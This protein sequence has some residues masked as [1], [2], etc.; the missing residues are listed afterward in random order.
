MSSTTPQ[1]YVIWKC[2]SFTSDHFHILIDPTCKRTR[3]SHEELP[4]ENDLVVAS[5]LH[6]LVLD[7]KSSHYMQKKYSA[8]GREVQVTKCLLMSSMKRENTLPKTGLVFISFLTLLIDFLTIFSTELTHHRK[9]RTL[10]IKEPDTELQSV[11]VFCDQHSHIDSWLLSRWK[12]SLLLFPFS[13]VLP[14]PQSWN[15]FTDNCAQS[16]QE[17]YFVFERT[18][19]CVRVQTYCI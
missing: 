14:F 10:W 6:L 7:P 18:L 4:I 12:L 2:N 17:I 1:V 16:N 5:A 19:V 13:C 11:L 9:C 15:P 8:A 3:S